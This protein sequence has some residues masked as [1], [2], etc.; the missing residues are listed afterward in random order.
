MF[1]IEWDDCECCTPW[2][3][4]KFSRSNFLV[5]FW[6]VMAEKCKYYYCHRKS[7]ICH[8]MAP[9]RMFYIMTYILKVT[10][11]EIESLRKILKY[12]FC[13]DWYLPSNGTIADVVL[14]DLDLTFKCPT[15][16]V[17]IL[18]RMN[19]KVL[20]R[21]C[22]TAKCNELYHLKWNINAWDTAIPLHGRRFVRYLGICNPICIKLLQL[23]SGIITH[24]SVT[25]RS[26]CINKLLSCSQL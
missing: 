2:P 11:F 12:D 21:S 6:Q 25:K 23:M 16:Q 9:L 1:A 26:L 10:N 4:N 14:R 20:P 19:K 8:W 24:T 7:G 18:T 17:A 3:W 5:D 22:H 15:F 13:G